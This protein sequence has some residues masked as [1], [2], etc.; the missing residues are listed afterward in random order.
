MLLQINVWFGKHSKFLF[1]VV[2]PLYVTAGRKRGDLRIYLQSPS[3]TR[4]TLLDARPQDYSSSGFIDWPF[5]SVHHW[6]ENP[7]G[8]W[9]LEVHNDA[10]SKW[11]SEA[12]FHKWSLELYGTAFDP[13][14]EAYR[15]QERFNV[16]REASLNE[17]EAEDPFPM[18]P[19]VS[20]STPATTTTASTVTTATIAVG[21]RGCVSKQHACTRDVSNCRR[22]SH[23]RVA[24]VFCECLAGCLEVAATSSAGQ[25]NLQCDMNAEGRRNDQPFY[26]RFIPFFSL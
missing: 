12:K 16:V 23:R 17:G 8:T 11:A 13:N 24:A 5:M 1:Q 15:E 21:D 25:F 9:I 22:F 20:T 19:V 7:T 6:G 10:F 18:L 26:C 4:S 14:T 3:G 2:V